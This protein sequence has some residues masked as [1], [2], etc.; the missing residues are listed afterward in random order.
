MA[1]RSPS[2]FRP[3]RAG[4][5]ICLLLAQGGCAIL[6]RRWPDAGTGGF[7]EYYATPDPRAHALGERLADLEARQ[8]RTYAAAEFDEASMLMVR[9][10]RE[11]AADHP[12]DAAENMDKLEII[13]ERMQRR[14]ARGRGRA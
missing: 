4:L 3:F 5:V 12:E 2:S 9:I 1:L 6:E 11:V 13:L 8:A 14:M 10:R 7:G